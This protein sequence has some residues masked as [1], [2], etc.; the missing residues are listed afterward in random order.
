MAGAKA[1]P[2]R[3][4]RGAVCKVFE[5]LRKVVWGVAT[6]RA[7]YITD[8]M[9]PDQALDQAIADME[10]LRNGLTLASLGKTLPQ[11]PKDAAQHM[12]SECLS[13]KYGGSA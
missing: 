11:V 12:R 10:S 1:P 13:P 3:R 9:C 5:R 2:W 4:G 7:F 6:R 8:H